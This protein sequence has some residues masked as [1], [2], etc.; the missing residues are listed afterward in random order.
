MKCARSRTI[1]GAKLA[2][3][4]LC[5]LLCAWLPSPVLGQYEALFDT[6][7]VERRLT[8]RLSL[9]P[10]DVNL[11]RPI[12]QREN[13]NLVSLYFHV[14]DVNSTDFLGLWDAVRA[15][16]AIA[17]KSWPANLRPRQKQALSCARTEFETRI[18]EKWLD[19][20]L[21]TL[22]EW[23]ELDWIQMKYVEKLFKSEHVARLEIFEKEKRLSIRLDYQWQELSVR[24]EVKM[25]QILDKLQLREY[26][27]MTTIPR[28]L[29]K[30]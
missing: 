16:N 24:R 19:D 2:A 10:S 11:L 26:H 18:L 30:K 14:S 29:A 17:D 8:T 15:R 1:K 21:Q 23:L 25:E 20:Y 4:M 28:F 7:S 12:M 3:V 22:G 6:A 5:S 9:K 13:D 27:Q